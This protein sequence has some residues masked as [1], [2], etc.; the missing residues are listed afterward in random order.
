MFAHIFVPKFLWKV[1][2]YMHFVCKNMPFVCFHKSPI[3]P[4]ICRNIPL[5][6]MT[7]VSSRV[8]GF[9]LIE[10]MVTIVL[11]GI[12]VTVAT[13]MFRNTIQNARISSQANDFL[14]DL[15]YARSE[16]IKR[17]ALVT[18]CKRPSDG[19]VTC[20]TTAGNPWTNGWVIFLDTNDNGQVDTAGTPEPILR[21]GAALEGGNVLNAVAPGATAE[22][23]DPDGKTAK[24]YQSLVVFKPSG[25]TSINISLSGS[26]RLCD[27]RGKDQARTIILAATGQGRVA[28]PPAI[29]CP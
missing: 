15:A 1:D 11:M 28:P 9:T 20:D 2:N 18:I 14:T 4:F 29:A 22:T 23:R 21:V 13:P 19:S 8:R 10:L 27:K 3:E 7:P 17:A 26:Y 24:S 5:I 25:T 12:L 16:A 6:D